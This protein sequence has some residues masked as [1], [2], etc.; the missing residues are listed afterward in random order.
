MEHSATRTRTL[1]RKL[2]ET[3]LKWVR[4]SGVFITRDL[5]G[6]NQRWAHSATERN[7]TSR[8]F[9][10]SFAE[11]LCLTLFASG[12]YTES[13]G[14]LLVQPLMQT[15]IARS[16]G[17]L[18]ALFVVL[19]TITPLRLHAQ[20]GA[21][22]R[23]A[24][25][26]VVDD[27]GEPV[28]GLGVSDFVVTEDGARREVLR[29]SRAIEPIDIALLVDNSSAA[30]NEIQNVR[31]GLTRFVEQMRDSNDIAIIGL[32]DRPT[33]LADYSRGQKSLASGI[34]RIFAQP[35]S[36]MTL[37]DAIV[38]TSKGLEK[39]EGP[40]AVILA[41]LTEGTEF[42]NLHYRNVL[43][44]LKK[45]GA[46][47][48]ALT[49]G[50]AASPLSDPLRNR[51]IVFDQGTR[52]SGGHHDTVLSSLA[53]EQSLERIGRQLKAQYKVVYGRPESLVPPESFEVSVTRPG[54]TAR[55]TP[56]RRQ[57]S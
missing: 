49:I 23:T 52:T 13:T 38:E 50:P 20:A 57:G 3:R 34:G 56:A 27:R 29:V 25:V 11:S 55:G 7:A 42:S 45:S 12:P 16:P 32:A 53:V 47:F 39:R 8:V 28:E 37:L 6:V 40:R 43:D 17:V 14:R 51:A 24:Y 54:L 5:G 2:L 21:R 46:A 36:G 44:A 18:A 9:S 30:T 48:Y 31:D 1:S 22:E 19:A 10:R 41:I 33:I 35:S 26:S 4:K 15:L